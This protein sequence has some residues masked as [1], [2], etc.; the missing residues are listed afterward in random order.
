MSL[1]IAHTRRIDAPRETVW[2]VITDLD[3]YPD[4]NPFMVECQSSLEEGAPIHMKVRV[5]PGINQPQKETIRQIEHARR[6]SYGIRLPLNAL[7]SDRYHYLEALADGTTHYVSRF[8][9]GGW[10]SP[11]V[12]LLL[13]SRLRKGFTHMTDALAERAEHL[14]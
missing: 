6:F 10:I 8:E 3:K 11:L 2:S 1:I 4:W 13:G 9:L 14:A 5:L 12:K 7:H